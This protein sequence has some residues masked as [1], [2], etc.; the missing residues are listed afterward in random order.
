MKPMLSRLE[1]L[2]RAALPS[3]VALLFLQSSGSWELIQAGRQHKH[4][5]HKDIESAKR[6]LR[7]ESTLIIIDV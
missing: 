6:R 1:R 3:E 4:S 2:E 7:A 5:V